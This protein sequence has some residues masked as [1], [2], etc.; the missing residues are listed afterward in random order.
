[1]E[2]GPEWCIRED[3]TIITVGQTLPILLELGLG[4]K[5]RQLIENKKSCKYFLF[6][7]GIS[8]QLRESLSNPPPSGGGGEG[9]QLGWDWNPLWGVGGS[10]FSEILQV[11]KLTNRSVA[12]LI[13]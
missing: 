6:S 2:G 10:K 8:V 1:M 9:W 3:M 13:I 11:K 7:C 12:I 4:S 5:A